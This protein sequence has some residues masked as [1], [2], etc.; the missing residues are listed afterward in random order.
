MRI[1]EHREIGRPDVETFRVFGIQA[2]Y[3]DNCWM[4][5]AGTCSF[6]A[7]AS[8]QTVPVDATPVVSGVKLAPVLEV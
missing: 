3:S 5:K 2:G 7:Q 1:C 4:D 6:A 8:L